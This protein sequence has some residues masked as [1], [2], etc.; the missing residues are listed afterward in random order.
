MPS[1]DLVLMYNEGP[2]NS[3]GQRD[4]AALGLG[5]Y[6]GEE[7]LCPAGFLHILQSGPGSRGKRTPPLRNKQI[8]FELDLK[9]NSKE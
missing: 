9:I 4:P 5:Y 1:T 8:P 7:N 2:Q 6:S 3:H